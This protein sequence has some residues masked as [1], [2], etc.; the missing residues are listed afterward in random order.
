MFVMA[1]RRTF[2]ATTVLGAAG[3]AVRTRAQPLGNRAWIDVHHHILP[4]AYVEAAGSAAIGAPGGRAVAPR[5]SVELSL[6]TMDQAGI[7]TAMTSVSAPAV[8]PQGGGTAERQRVQRLVRSF[9]EFSRKMAVDHP[10]RFGTFATLCLPDVDASLVG[11]HLC[12]RSAPRR[13][14]R[15]VDQLRRSV[16]GGTLLSLRCS[17]S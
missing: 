13:R 1:S 2:L 10:G 7:T 3:L 12:L 15:A 17:M 8:S 6:E 9:N 16:P 4:P 14:R 5:W 11:A